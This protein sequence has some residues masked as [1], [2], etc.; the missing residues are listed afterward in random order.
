M[1][2]QRGALASPFECTKGSLRGSNTLEKSL[3]LPGRNEE[4]LE[5]SPRKVLTLC[6]NLC[7]EDCK[8]ET[9]SVGQAS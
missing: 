2:L 9:K 7:W 6:G 5:H 8:Q 1:A 4:L 3:R